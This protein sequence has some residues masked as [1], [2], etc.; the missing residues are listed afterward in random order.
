ML[1][2]IQLVLKVMCVYTVT[3]FFLK[4]LIILLR[5]VCWVSLIRL[6]SSYSIL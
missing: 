2:I 4:F 3:A 1:E 5:T 6:K